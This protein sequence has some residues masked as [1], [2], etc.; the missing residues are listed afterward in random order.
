MLRYLHEAGVGLHHVSALLAGTMVHVAVEF[1]EAGKEVLL[2][3][4]EHEAV[5]MQQ[6]V[7][8]FAIPL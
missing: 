1:A 5:F 8:R 7:A 2:D 4:V 6:V 3:V